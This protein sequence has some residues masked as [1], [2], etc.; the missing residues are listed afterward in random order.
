[1]KTSPEGPRRRAFLLWEA[2]NAKKKELITDVWSFDGQVRIK[3]LDNR[4]YKV[5][6]TDELNRLVPDYVPVQPRAIY[7]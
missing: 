3:T 4:V 5:A 1:M 7:T 2:R 6:S